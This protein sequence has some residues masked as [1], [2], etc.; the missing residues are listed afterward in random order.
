MFWYWYFFKDEK[1]SITKYMSVLIA[2]LGQSYKIGHTA[3]LISQGTTQP[4]SQDIFA[5]QHLYSSNVWQLSFS[6][7]SLQLE[8]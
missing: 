8:I 3:A 6:F 5:G 4:A 1:F 7:G 2:T